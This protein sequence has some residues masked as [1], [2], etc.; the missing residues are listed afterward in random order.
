MRIVTRV[1]MLPHVSCGRRR[2]GG[3]SESA[4]ERLARAQAIMLTRVVVLPVASIV[5]R[6]AGTS[7]VETLE[8]VE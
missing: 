3:K 6:D 5:R 8:Y 7:L 1:L 4:W 2:P